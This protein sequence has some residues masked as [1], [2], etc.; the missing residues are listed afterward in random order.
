MYDL[1]M[2]CSFLERDLMLH[3]SLLQRA[4]LSL[5]NVIFF[6]LKNKQCLYVCRLRGKTQGKKGP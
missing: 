5:I 1:K 6:Y 2:M 3:V 4:A